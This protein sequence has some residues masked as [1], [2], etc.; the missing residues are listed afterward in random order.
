MNCEHDEYGHG[1]LVLPQGDIA[2]NEYRL[3]QADLAEV[4]PERAE[5]RPAGFPDHALES[6]SASGQRQ[7]AVQHVHDCVESERNQD[8]GYQHHH[9]ELDGNGERQHGISDSV[10]RVVDVAVDRCRNAECQEQGCQIQYRQPVPGSHCI[11][12]QQHDQPVGQ[13]QT[14]H[15][16]CGRPDSPYSGFQVRDREHSCADKSFRGAVGSPNST[17]D[18]PPFQYF[19]PGT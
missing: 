4:G 8:G 6:P 7:S 10:R 3:V 16:C 17:H 14:G 15:Y 13:V 2:Q 9:S 12:S 5:I 18:P 11:L 19:C 1:C